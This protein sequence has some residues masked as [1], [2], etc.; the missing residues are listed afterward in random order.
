MLISSSKACYHVNGKLPYRCIKLSK[1]VPDCGQIC[2]EL[3]SCIGISEGEYCSFFPS[4]EIVCP[5]GW[6]MHS[7]DV[8][9]SKKDLMAGNLD[10]YNCKFKQG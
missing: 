1:D 2:N 3:D 5:V 10:A 8:T 4:S 7:G 9:S 6:T